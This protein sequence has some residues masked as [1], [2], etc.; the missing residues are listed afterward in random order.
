MLVV[1]ILLGMLIVSQVK[2]FE[3]INSTLARE[4]TDNIFQQLKILKGKNDALRQEVSKLESNLSQ[5][6]NKES[7]LAIVKSEINELMKLEGQV[8]VF[9]EGVVITFDGNIGSELMTDMLNELFN[10]GA[11]SVTINGLRHTTTTA[12]FDLLPNRQIFYAGQILTPPITFAGIGDSKKI[13]EI[14]DSQG[15]IISRIKDS[16]KDMAIQVEAR[17]VIQM[18]STT[19]NSAFVD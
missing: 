9:G 19:Q 7:A 3:L 14:L 4:N 5:L 13:M 18:G 17:S 2:T 15:G 12:G 11:Q 1:S 8:G 10:A 6:F 16:N